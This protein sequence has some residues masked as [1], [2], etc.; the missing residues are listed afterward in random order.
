MWRHVGYLWLTGDMTWHEYNLC[1]AF[2]RHGSYG[3]RL[4]SEC[5]GVWFLEWTG[6]FSFLQNVNTSSGA[7]PT[8]YSVNTGRYTFPGLG[9]L[10]HEPTIHLH[11]LQGLTVSGVTLL[12]P[13][14]SFLVCI[15]TN[16]TLQSCKSCNSVLQQARSAC[17][18]SWSVPKLCY[19]NI[20]AFSCRCQ[21][22]EH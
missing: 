15:L 16:L 11:L 1:N 2:C 10:G 13:L 21:M 8:F 5:F 12:F 4:S 17:S 7:H 14:Y 19:I 6:D 22:E 18:P 20:A 9:W 3:A